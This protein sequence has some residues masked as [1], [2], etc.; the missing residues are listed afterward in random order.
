MPRR[1]LFELRRLSLVEH[2]SFHL[3]VDLDVDV[4]GVDG[5]VS[6]PV[7]DGVDVVS[8]TQ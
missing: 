1:M 5:G 2:L 4:G 6:K 8:G 3:H 7:A